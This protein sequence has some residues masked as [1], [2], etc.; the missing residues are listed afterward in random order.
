MESALLVG[1]RRLPGPVPTTTP[2]PATTPTPP[3]PIPPPT[4]E[5][6]LSF[7]IL[8]LMPP[9]PHTE[10]VISPDSKRITIP[11]PPSFP[12]GDVQPIV[13][14]FNRQYKECRFLADPTNSYIQ[15]VSDSTELLKQARIFLTDILYETRVVMVPS[16]IDVI[17]DT[18]YLSEKRK[19]TVKKADI[20]HEKVDVIVNAADSWLSL[21]G[22]MARSLD[23]A[24]HG[25]LQ[26]HST[27]YIERHGEV[28]AGSACVTRGGGSLK[29]NYVIHAVGPQDPA[30]YSDH[31][32]ISK[33]I[34]DAIYMSILEAE[35]LN[36]VSIAFVP[37]TY[38]V[39]G[40][41]DE[42]AA[43]VIFGAILY[44]NL[45]QDTNVLTDIRIVVFDQP[46]YACF[47]N[48]MARKQAEMQARKRAADHKR[49]NR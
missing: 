38:G 47:V 19:L 7:D 48:T 33:V 16:T 32:E 12:K 35:K 5:P 41:S 36:A 44:Y 43:D 15:T 21:S 29:C 3:S 8:P 17:S 25:E 14:E 31:M 18:I 42:V 39:I 49:Q 37:L 34:F 23:Q 26:T 2:V 6:G 20:A 46:T 4:T 9:L 24:S 30:N 10:L 11:V 13:D 45:P 27:R 28:P 1:F 40:V 22:G